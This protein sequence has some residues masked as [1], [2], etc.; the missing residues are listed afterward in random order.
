MKVEEVHPSRMRLLNPLSWV[1]LNPPTSFPA[2]D[3]THF[4]V[5][6]LGQEYTLHAKRSVGDLEERH[7]EKVM[8]R[9]S[10]CGDEF[11]VLTIFS[12]RLAIFNS[13]D[14]KWIII[15]HALWY[16]DL[17]LFRGDFYAVDCT[18]R[19]VL[20]DLSLDVSLVAESICDCGIQKFLVESDGGLLLVDVY[21]SFG[22]VDDCDI[23]EV[24]DIFWMERNFQFKVF[25][26]DIKGKRWVEVESLRLRDRL[27]FLGESCSFSASVGEF[28]KGNCILFMDNFFGARGKENSGGGSG[29]DTFV[30]D[31]DTYS[32]ALLT[33]CPEYSRLFWPPPDWVLMTHLTVSIYSFN[34]F[35]AIISYMT[36]Y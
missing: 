29:T 14:E 34:L 36:S 12:G 32:I 18:G 27:I 19:V 13:W 28:I 1:Q 9:S 20:V 5:L 21:L 4:K 8:L 30:F 25:E 15:P 16:D 33:D 17:I 11:S 24:F 22:D 10:G 7:K 26:L 6:E 31:L 23:D 2:I 3:L 35:F